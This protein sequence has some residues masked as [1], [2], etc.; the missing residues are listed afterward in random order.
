MKGQES[1]LSPLKGTVHA[2]PARRNDFNVRNHLLQTIARP[3]INHKHCRRHNGPRLLSLKFESLRLKRI[4]NPGSALLAFLHSL[5]TTFPTL[6]TSLSSLFFRLTALDIIPSR[7]S[8]TSLYW[9]CSGELTTLWIWCQSSS[10]LFHR[11]VLLILTY[12]GF[13]NTLLLLLSQNCYWIEKFEAWRRDWGRLLT[14]YPVH[15]GDT[16]ANLKTSY[17]CP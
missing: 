9:F 13:C 12:I 17:Q 11:V 6:C 15:L 10:S 5:V 7:A 14:K 4:Q 1:F 8:C 3:H 16:F 2:D